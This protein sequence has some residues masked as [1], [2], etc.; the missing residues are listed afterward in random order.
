MRFRS[1]TVLAVLAVASLAH[2]EPTLQIPKLG[3]FP[4]QFVKVIPVDMRVENASFSIQVPRG[5]TVA[6]EGVNDRFND[7]ILVTATADPTTARTYAGV[8]VF[9][10]PPPAGYT[11]EHKFAREERRLKPGEKLRYAAWQGRRWVVKEYNCRRALYD[12]R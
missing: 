10:A 9:V 8:H 5:W 12:A 3:P 11:L 7:N 4:D 1:L 6:G 2:A